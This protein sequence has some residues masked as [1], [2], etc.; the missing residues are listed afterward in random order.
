MQMDD[1]SRPMLP[2]GSGGLSGAA[3]HALAVRLVRMAAQAV[4]IP[5][6]GIGG[7]I[8]G[9][10]AAEML[11]AGAVAVEVGTANFYDPRASVRIARELRE[12]CERAGITR[13]TELSR[14][15]SQA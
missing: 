6:V 14:A 2:R 10:D 7:V 8:C 3:I 5:V 1:G 11:R 4:R 15:K 13:V 12:Y 9:A